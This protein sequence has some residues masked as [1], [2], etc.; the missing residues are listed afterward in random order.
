M[1]RLIQKF[2]YWLAISVLTFGL[3]SCAQKPTSDN[4]S[5]L[6]NDIGGLATVTDIV[7]A[8]INE[9]AF[10][11]TIYPYF[12]KSNIERFRQKMIEHLCAE[13]GGRCNYSGDSMKQVHAGMNITEA[14]F[15]LTVELLIKAMKKAE[16]SYPNQNRILKILAPMRKDVLDS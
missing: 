15:N 5:S 2:N 14:H 10:D 13:T 12:E 4:N 1:K 8:F 11:Q 6:F 16:V 7:D 3:I 9:I